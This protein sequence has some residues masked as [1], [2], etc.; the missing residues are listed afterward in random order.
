MRA[1]EPGQ[2]GA[3]QRAKL[4]II[5]DGD[6]YVELCHAL[7]RDHDY[8]TR[9]ELAGPC[10]TCQRRPGCRLTHAHDWA[11][12]LQALGRHP[13][14]Q[15]VLLDLAFDLPLERLLL[16]SDGDRELSRRLQG[17][18][19]L[20]A[21]RGRYPDLPVLLMTS[22]EELPPD[23]AAE[24]LS[25]DEFVTMAGPDLFDARA[26]GLLIERILARRAA[27]TERPGY[28]WGRSAAMAGLR[29]DAL[30]LGRTS[31][32]M[33]LLGETG[34]GKSAL[35]ERV[36]HPATRR[37]GPFLAVDLAAIPATLIAAELFGTVRGAFSGAVDR[38][39]CFER[40]SGGTLFLDE[41][42][43]LPPEVQRSLLLTLQSGRITRLG[44]SRLRQVDVKLIAA[45]NTDLKGAVREGAFRKDLYARLNPAARMVLAP[46][47][48]RKEDIRELAAA[49]IAGRF[50][51]GTDR[52]LLASYM[53]VAG[54][55]GPVRAVLLGEGE[56]EPPGQG[57]GFALSRRAMSALRSHRWP[58]NIREL[59]LCLANAAIYAL[60][61]A[62]RAA[63]SGTAVAATAPRTIPIPAKLL[64]ELLGTWSASGDS[65][66]TASQ[67]QGLYVR[68]SP[69]TSLKQ[70]ARD[71]EKQ[72]YAEL[73][74][75]TKG[76]FGKM[77]QR[78]L[79]GDAETNARRVRLRFNQ[80]GLR[81]RDL[82]KKFYK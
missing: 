53:Q 69:G 28:L 15:A 41:I 30:A 7:L 8:A 49:F 70:V 25:V 80:L 60:S 12:T 54:L 40:A 76:D 77:A 51:A 18:E 37:Q 62:L 13:D 20:R 27:V 57:V 48:E 63:E 26:L 59:E 31:L 19:I 21:L 16:R 33:L 67:K 65:A 52:E 81:A 50:A 23:A 46:L 22:L 66:L 14:L 78:L 39:G 79:K 38:E 2:G 72:L 64:H 61:D 10:W 73:F 11:E 56:T 75:E 58:G 42:G 43:N 24:A 9:C 1:S 68:L 29:Q 32:P 74:E 6:R 4:L 17:L 5:D 34:T 35:A 71:A 47:R 82:R 45:T 44:E 55:D 3:R 36:L